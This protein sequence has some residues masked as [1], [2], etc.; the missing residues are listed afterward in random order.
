[1]SKL[2]GKV[3]CILKHFF[4]LLLFAYQTFLEKYHVLRIGAL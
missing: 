2:Q 1:M 3:V 4:I